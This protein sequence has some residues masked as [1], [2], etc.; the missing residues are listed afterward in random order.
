LR[1]EVGETPAKIALLLTRESF[2]SHSGHRQAEHAIADELKALIGFLP[3]S[4]GSRS[5]GQGFPSED[6]GV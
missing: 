3:P 4:L 5:M 6:L 2:A 1:N